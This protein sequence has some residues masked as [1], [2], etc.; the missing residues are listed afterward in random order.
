MSTSEGYVKRNI[1]CY[2][3]SNVW[4]HKPGPDLERFPYHVRWPGVLSKLL[5][6]DINVIEE[7]LCGRTVITDNPIE[8]AGGIERNGYKTFGAILETHSPID[9]VILMLGVN[10][11]KHTAKMT[12]ADIAEGIAVL[13]EFARSP[14]FGPGFSDSPDIL[15]IC[16]PAI[17]EV[18]A[19][20]GPR[21]KGGRETS[22][23]FRDAFRRASQRYN[24]PVIYAEDFVQPDP[25][26]G[27][28]FS[29]ESH[30]VLAQEVARWILEKYNDI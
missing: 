12:A 26:D 19:N 27:L 21:F 5:R 24:F 13:A 6:T 2:G 7:G 23:G 18:E 1:L 9:M 15:V 10:E 17:W 16:P 3:D 28:H 20:F 4:G 8:S 30:T 25:I 29:A 14:I 11:L 22:L